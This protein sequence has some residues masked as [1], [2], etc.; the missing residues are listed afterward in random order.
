MIHITVFYVGFVAIVN[1][2][3]GYTLAVYLGHAQPWPT[4]MGIRRSRGGSSPRL[5]P[6]PRTE[7]PPEDEQRKYAQLVQEELSSDP[8]MEASTKSAVARATESVLND[9]FD[10]W[11]AEDPART[12]TL[13]A[14]LID[15]DQIEEI[16]ETH[17]ELLIDQL[18]KVLE[19][20]VREVAHE[21]GSIT[22][23]GKHR[24]LMTYPDT[25][26]TDA[27]TAVEQLRQTIE[28]TVFRRGD[29]ELHAT[30]SCAVVEVLSD[31]T[32]ESL[33]ERVECTLEE[34]Q[35]YGRNRTFL[36]EGEY[37]TPVM[38]PE[39]TVEDLVRPL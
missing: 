9:V 35:Q 19:S 2:A 24:F 34:A 3:L 32:R 31:D 27:V 38:P 6:A 22:Q 30:V 28:N 14:A 7:H 11:L 12:R 29:Q 18:L 1:L 5:K 16:R 13:C 8:E 37:P 21:E 36:H 33:L 23:L 26:P 10:K 20:M 39:L 15:I 17:G 25:R 4:G